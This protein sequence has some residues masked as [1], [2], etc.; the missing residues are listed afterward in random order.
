MKRLQILEHEAAYVKDGPRDKISSTTSVVTAGSVQ[1]NSTWSSI[2]RAYGWT[3]CGDDASHPDETMSCSHRD[4]EDFALGLTHATVNL[5][6]PG[7]AKDI[8]GNPSLRI[9]KAETENFR[10]KEINIVPGGDTKVPAWLADAP[11]NF[12]LG[13]M[14]SR[15]ESNSIDGIFDSVFG[16]I[17]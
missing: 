1:S 9:T 5:S 17:H 6:G 10:L 4:S 13:C 12:V 11:H 2:F 16:S 14:P 7:L 3:F 8:G 15:P